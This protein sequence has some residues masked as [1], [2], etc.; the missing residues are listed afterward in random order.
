MV[1]ELVRKLSNAVIYNIT[2]ALSVNEEDR[3]DE[4][5]ESSRPGSV[6]ISALNE[7]TI[8]KIFQYLSISELINTSLVCKRWQHLSFDGSLW[9]NVDLRHFAQTLHDEQALRFVTNAYLVQKVETLDLSGF[10]VSHMTLNSLA[11]NCPDLRKLVLKSVTFSIHEE[12]AEK[13]VLFPADLEHLD[14]RYS[15]GDAAVYQAMA[16]SLT[17]VKW[18][19]LCDAF[20]LAV[21]AQQTLQQTVSSLEKLEK[22]DLTHCNL[23]KDEFVEAFG[24]CCRLKVLSLRKCTHI[25]GEFLPKIIPQLPCLET[26]I[27]NSTSIEDEPLNEVDWVNSKIKYLDIGCCPLISSKGLDSLLPIVAQMPYLEYFGLCRV[28]EGRALTDDNLQ[29]FAKQLQIGTC[30]ALKS[31]NLSLSN[32]ITDEGVESFQKAYPIETL[33]VS[34]CSQITDDD[35]DVFEL[36]NERKPSVTDSVISTMSDEGQKLTRKRSRGSFSTVQFALSNYS[37]ETPL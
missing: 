30:P 9:R 22:L 20:V 19:G 23:A 35:D 36:T 5:E 10:N 7:S 3:Q 11:S 17:K 31:L 16:R 25:E 6:Q 34:N 26:L 21:T 27:L 12:D 13:E 18:L 29:S 24:V 1:K 14:I 37:L 33:D 15:H 4:G 32:N 28:G 2:R 8:L